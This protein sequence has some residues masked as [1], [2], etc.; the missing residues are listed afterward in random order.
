MDQYA[1]YPAENICSTAGKQVGCPQ[2]S[3]DYSNWSMPKI[4]IRRVCR[5]FRHAPCKSTSEATPAAAFIAITPPPHTHTHTRWVCYFP[6]TGLVIGRAYSTRQHLY[7]SRPLQ[8]T[9]KAPCCSE[10]LRLVCLVPRGEL[11]Y[12]HVILI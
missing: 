6:I 12:N 9:S 7:T 5:D 2:Y 1:L 3:A 10:I 11:N 8:C 4:N